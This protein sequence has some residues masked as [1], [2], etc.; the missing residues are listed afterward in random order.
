MDGH[1]LASD[2]LIFPPGP[3]DAEDLAQVHVR[4]WRQTYPGLLPDLYLARLST[5]LHARRWRKR[6]LKATPGEVDLVAGDR[7]GLVAY[8]SGGPT[9]GG[10]EDEAEITTL[11]VLKSAQGQGLGRRLLAGAAR[12]LMAGGAGALTLTV[13]RGNDRAVA[14]Y[15]RLGGMAGPAQVRRGPG[16]GLVSEIPFRWPEIAELAAMDLED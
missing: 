11:Y 7:S 1:Q 6:L 5:P 10:A 9:R 15:D 14:F 13:L 2:Y 8:V 4:A 12:A 3:G 16:G